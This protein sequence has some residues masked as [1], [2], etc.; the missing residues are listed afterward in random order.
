MPLENPWER[1]L[2]RYRTGA[3]SHFLGRLVAKWKQLCLATDLV[4][5][6][7]WIDR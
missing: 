3:L 4:A 1:L 6:L 7:M 2:D 5:G